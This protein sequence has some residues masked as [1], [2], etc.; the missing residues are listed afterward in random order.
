MIPSLLQRLT[1]VNVLRMSLSKK[2]RD[3]YVWIPNSVIL[4]GSRLQVKN[5]G[6]SG[7]ERQKADIQLNAKKDMTID[8]NW[9]EEKKLC[10]TKFPSPTPISFLMV[11]SLTE[12]AS[13]PPGQTTGIW[14][15]G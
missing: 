7:R 11:S 8:V 1:E 13:M 4:S 14:K 6:F 9:C 15:I 12:G 10:S 3:S 2:S 5:T